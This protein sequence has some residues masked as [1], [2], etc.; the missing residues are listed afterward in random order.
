MRIV[1]ISSTRTR[2]RTEEEKMRGKRKEKKDL[3]QQSAISQNPA[4]EAT[5]LTR[6]YW[7]SAEI[8]SF[9]ALELRR[10]RLACYAAPC[11]PALVP[12]AVVLVAIVDIPQLPACPKI[13]DRDDR[14]EAH[15]KVNHNSRYGVDHG[16]W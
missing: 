13:L 8:L 4:F 11:A 2:K 3:C 7:L 10:H 12:Q 15:R 5:R 16:R 1:R 9:Q 6:S 14:K